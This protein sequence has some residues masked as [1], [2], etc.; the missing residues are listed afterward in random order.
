MERAY[1]LQEMSTSFP[2][3]TDLTKHVI[4]ILLPWMSSFLS[5]P[6]NISSAES[7]GYERES[8]IRDFPFWYKV[9]SGK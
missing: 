4:L 9:S 8:R 2:A 6:A 3:S 7:S 5:G 1:D